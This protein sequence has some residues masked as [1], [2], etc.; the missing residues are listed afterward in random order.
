[1]SDEDVEGTSV[2]PKEPAGYV[3]KLSD[4]SISSIKSAGGVGLHTESIRHLHWN[5][6][7]RRSQISC[8]CAIKN[9]LKIHQIGQLINSLESI[10]FP[11]FW[12]GIQHYQ[13]RI[14]E[15]TEA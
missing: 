10:G 1:M 15:A 2:A 11:L 9:K 13:L 7:K 5:E 8:Q 4:V 14:P 3:R 12:I 6:T